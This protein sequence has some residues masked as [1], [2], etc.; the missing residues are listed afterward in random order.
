[1]IF[2]IEAIMDER[3]NIYFV[4]DDDGVHAWHCN[5][6]HKNNYNVIKVKKV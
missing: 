1:M 3:G 2:R 5:Q 6:I 4:R